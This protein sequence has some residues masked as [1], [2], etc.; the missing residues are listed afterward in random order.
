MLLTEKGKSQI[1]FP[2]FCVAFV[3]ATINLILVLMGTDIFKVMY[4]PFSFV[5]NIAGT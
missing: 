3:V 1:L 5:G 2:S 4:V